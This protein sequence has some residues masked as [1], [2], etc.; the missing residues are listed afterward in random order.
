MISSP[1]NT[2]QSSW[3]V[4][5]R[6]A[7]ETYPADVT[8][9]FAVAGIDMAVLDDP[10]NRVPAEAMKKLWL[11]ATEIS[12]DEYFGLNAG[13]FVTPST[14]FAIGLSALT[15]ENILDAYR[16]AVYGADL[17][18]SGLNLSLSQEQNY[19]VFELSI[20]PGF[21]E[22]AP[23]GVDAGLAGLL[24][25]IRQYFGL[26]LTLEKLSLRRSSPSDPSIFESRFGC[27]V[28]FD[29][30]RNAAYLSNFEQLIQR[31]P[32]ANVTLRQINQALVEEQVRKLADDS[33][34]G[35]ISNEIQTRLKQGLPTDQQTVARAVYMGERKLQ[36]ALK[37]EGTSFQSILDHNRYH[38]AL[39]LLTRDKLSVTRIAL[40]L[41]F[42]EVSSFTRA[43]KRW[44]GKTPREFSSSS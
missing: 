44:T 34:S 21:P 8:Q 36:L 32:M 25:I 28:E 17:I 31:F 4:V 18:S 43:F 19:W 37:R 22:F 24:H 29:S 9:V 41:G 38:I 7:L 15:S 40:Q 3:A 10:L 5:I 33:L 1:T 39:Q 6:Q 23:Q 27:P 26:N 2:T 30:Q 11:A 13:R 14:F 42:R 16:I 20:K 35:R 12:G